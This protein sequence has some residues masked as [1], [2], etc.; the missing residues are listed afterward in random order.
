MDKE[1]LRYIPAGPVQEAYA[2][3]LPV[4]QFYNHIETGFISMTVQEYNALPV[5]VRQTWNLYKNIRAK[6]EKKK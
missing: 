2:E 5:Y 1:M 3:W 6:F 4:L